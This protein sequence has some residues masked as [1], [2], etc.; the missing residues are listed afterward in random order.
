MESCYFLARMR[1]LLRRPLFWLACAAVLAAAVFAVLRAR[2]PMVRSTVVEARALEQHIVASGR[3]WV[4]TRA[5]VS[6]QVPGLVVAVGA[7]EGQR[8][9]AGDLLVQIDDSEARAAVAQAQAAVDQANARVAQLRRVGAIVASE[10]LRQAQVSLEGAEQELARTEALARAGSATQAQLDDARRAAAVARA[11]K[12]AAEAQQISAAPL[13]A[14]SRVALTALLQAQAQLMGANVR[15]AQTRVTA[16]HDAVVLTRAVEPGDVVQPARTLLVMA[17]DANA[18]LVFH[19]DERNIAFIA[20]GQQARAS[21]DAY[22][23]ETFAAEVSYLAPSVDPQRGSIEVRLSV[24]EPPSFLKPDMTVSIDL[25]V[26]KRARALT[27]PSEAVIGA[28]SPDAFVWSIEGGRVARR[29]VKLG[30]RGEGTIEIAA[31][32]GEGAEVALPEGQRLEHGL[33]VRAE[34]D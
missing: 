3:V 9:K 27:L 21:A 20:L 11:Q 28:A 22:P 6:T 19:P 12:T 17:V 13:G 34:R 1:S 31:G 14:D 15:L 18:Q 32:L 26:A 29:P 23:Q 8:V 33:R 2:G 10:G 16:L 30:I 7:V 24:P 5:Q 25:T 4:P